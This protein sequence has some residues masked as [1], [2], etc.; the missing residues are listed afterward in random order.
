VAGCG[1]ATEQTLTTDN[2]MVTDISAGMPADV[3]VPEG[4][5]P[6][7]VDDTID[8]ITDA[9]MLKAGLT[10]TGAIND[11]QITV[12]CNPNAPSITYTINS[13]DKKGEGARF[14]TDFMMGN[15]VNQIIYRPDNRPA[16]TALT[17]SPQYNNETQISGEQAFDAANARRLTLR[18]QF[19]NA[20]ETYV[21]DQSTAD[22]QTVVGACLQTR[23][24]NARLEQR[25]AAAEARE[26]EEQAAAEAAANRPEDLMPDPEQQRT[27][28]EPANSY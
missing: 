5:G 12:A 28:S 15:P 20:N 14:D 22:F 25:K 18:A 10:V 16:K 1:P 27:S 19:V 26:R 4:D 13:F 21:V 17:L 23:L 9:R 3:D 6:W 2:T 24:A 11:V 7:S 8:P